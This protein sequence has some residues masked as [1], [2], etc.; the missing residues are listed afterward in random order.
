MSKRL[1]FIVVSVGMF[2]ITFGGGAL[3]ELVLAAN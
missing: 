3:Y 2:A 1:E